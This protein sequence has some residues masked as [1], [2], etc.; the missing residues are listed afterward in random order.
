MPEKRY[1]IKLTEE[2]RSQ[3]IE[4][5]DA[6]KGSKERRRRANVL[7]LCDETNHGPAMT[8]AEVARA[9]R[10]RSKTVARVRQRCF[11]SGVEAAVERAPRASDCDASRRTFD[12]ETEARLVEIACSPAPEGYAHWSLRLLADKLV[13]LEVVEAVSHS[14][15]G[16]TLKKTSSNRGW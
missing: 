4:V 12:G 1:R 14:T 11:E 6:K 2:E 10:C 7:L 15:V 16:R 8:D 9:L 3:L 13:E 5:S